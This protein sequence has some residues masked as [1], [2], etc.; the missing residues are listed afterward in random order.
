MKALGSPVELVLR[1]VRPGWAVYEV[2]EGDVRG[3]EVLLEADLDELREESASVAELAWCGDLKA[4]EQKRLHRLGARIHAST[5]AIAGRPKGDGVVPFVLRPPR[6]AED[7]WRDLEQVAWEAAIDERKRPLVSTGGVLLRGVH[8]EPAPVLELEKS[9]LKT[10]TLACDPPL[11]RFDCKPIVEEIGAAHRALGG[12]GACNKVVEGEDT[13][14]QLEALAGKDPTWH[15]V[16]VLAHGYRAPDVVSL[17][18]LEDHANTVQHHV[19]AER[20]A[21]LKDVRLVVLGVCH[22]SPLAFEIARR[23]PGARVVGLVDRMQR[24]TLQTFFRHFYRALLDPSGPRARHAE[25]AFWLALKE[26]F[27]AGE[28]EWFLPVMYVPSSLPPL[29]DVGDVQVFDRAIQLANEGNTKR[30]LQILKGYVSSP[31]APIAARAKKL[32]EETDRVSALRASLGELEDDI[33]LQAARPARNWSALLDAWSKRIPDLPGTAGAV[34]VDP[35]GGRRKVELLREL[36]GRL[37]ESVSLGVDALGD[38]AAVSSGTLPRLPEACSKLV[39]AGS[40]GPGQP[41]GALPDLA[42]EIYAV[43]LSGWLAERGREIDNAEGPEDLAE[44]VRALRIA[45]DL[46]L[47]AEPA[48]KL[49]DEERDRLQAS[50]AALTESLRSRVLERLSGASRPSAEL[51][52]PGARAELLR[53]LSGERS[54]DGAGQD[55]PDDLAGL[56]SYLASA[57]PA[58]DSEATDLASLPPELAS[59]M[60]NEVAPIQLGR[61]LDAP[62]DYLVLSAAGAHPGMSAGEILKLTPSHDSPRTKRLQQGSLRRLSKP[63]PRLEV[64]ATFLPATNP[65]A[66]N[67]ALRALFEAVAEGATCVPDALLEGLAPADRVAVL[68]AGG[69]VSEAV[70]EAWAGVAPS[71]ESTRPLVQL[72]G[73]RGAYLICLHAASLTDDPGLF[74]DLYHR[75]IALLGALRGCRSGVRAWVGQRFDVYGLPR[76]ADLG[77]LVEVVKDRLAGLLG[78]CLAEHESRTGDLELVRRLRALDEQE[79]LG[80]SSSSALESVPGGTAM[81]FQLARRLGYLGAVAEELSGVYT[82]LLVMSKAEYVRFAQRMTVETFHDLVF[83]FSELGSLLGSTGGEDP[84]SLL[85]DPD[86]LEEGE[87]GEGANE[88][89]DAP[90]FGE[91]FPFHAN[92]R[93]EERG[94]VLSAHVAMLAGRRIFEELRRELSRSTPRLSTAKRALRELKDLDAY[95]EA[96]RYRLAGRRVSCGGDVEGLLC[97][98]ADKAIGATREYD[99]EKQGGAGDKDGEAL[100]GRLV[101]ACRLA[102]A[103]ESVRHPATLGSTVVTRAWAKLRADVAIFITNAYKSHV[104][105]YDLLRSAVRAL[106]TPH[107]VCNFLKISAIRSIELK[108]ESKHQ[109][110]RLL[111]GEGIQVGDSFLERNPD[112]NP[113]DKTV[114]ELR[115]DLSRLRDLMQG[116]RTQARPTLVPVP[117]KEG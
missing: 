28:P 39:R 99:A 62:H 33:K 53:W 46:L 52:L 64:D 63:K 69:R 50:L 76:P 97:E 92:L 20:L 47:S 42:G 106:E 24:E 115:S 13:L 45:E 75:C 29:L 116:R 65:P 66:A 103:L 117:V 91:R 21:A 41:G 15:V 3:L 87:V 89:L 78:D 1:R 4:T 112:L 81:G 93:D 74:E 51:L 30:A 6:S 26:L 27:L 95:L 40:L 34:A 19:L 79:M 98:W 109:E 71:L 107:I 31:S 111:C 83:S 82:E 70:E 57:P 68:A 96:L 14:S 114:Q 101:R 88:L 23:L 25:I 90:D 56:E 49:S 110:A 104:Q 94:R 7:A 77:E 43:E 9:P 36:H 32:V 10:L 16:N 102:G 2:H 55:I 48:A 12:S 80:V 22:S 108:E 58:S 44:V 11:E 5:C 105:A 60:L 73:L 61:S 17:H 59:V 18:G 100:E 8:G 67:A 85:P 35:R 84:K 72:E 113:D 37:S 54:S 86:R 38:L